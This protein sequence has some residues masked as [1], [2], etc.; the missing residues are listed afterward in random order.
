MLSLNVLTLCGLVI[1][2]ANINLDQHWLRHLTCC[3]KSLHEPMLISHQRCFVAFT[4]E[5]RNLIPNM[6]RD[7]IFKITITSP[8]GQR[9][10]KSLSLTTHHDRTIW[11]CAQ[12][13][14]DLKLWLHHMAKQSWYTTVN[15]ISNKDYSTS[16]RNPSKVITDVT[17]GCPLRFFLNS[18][19]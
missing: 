5:L 7:Y 3:L 6:F 18:K 14:S 11:F 1:P 8:R 9:V 16:Q 2:Y 15:W 4:W 13:V 19:I 17:Q 12:G 10:N